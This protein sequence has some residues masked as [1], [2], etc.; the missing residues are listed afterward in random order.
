MSA[1][2]DW[3]AA[4][5]ATATA[6]TRKAMTGAAV[7]GDSLGYTVE[8][9]DGA[10]VYVGRQCCKYCARSEAANIVAGRLENGTPLCDYA[11]AAP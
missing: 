8:L 9:R 1:C 10:Q 6:A 11:K 5:N 2:R 4:V 3:L 7:L